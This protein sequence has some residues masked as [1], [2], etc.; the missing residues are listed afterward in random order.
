MKKIKLSEILKLANVKRAIALMMALT[1]LTLAGCKGN[2]ASSS[3]GGSSSEPSKVE[4]TD[5]SDASSEETVDSSADSTTTPSITTPSVTTPVESEDTNA[6]TS[7]YYIDPLKGDISVDPSITTEAPRKDAEELVPTVDPSNLC[8]KYEGYAQKE[9]DA[10]LDEILNTKNTLEY[11]KPKKGAK[12]YYVSPGGNNANDGLSHENAIQTID[13]VY[14]L[15]LLPGDFVLFERNS[16]YRMTEAFELREGVTYGSY[17]EG[18]KPMFYGSSR[19]YAKV[20]WKPSKKKNVWQTSYLDTYPCGMFFNEGE[21]FGYLKLTLRAVEKNTDFFYDE[22]NATFY[23]YCDR[24]N[25]SNVWDSIEISQDKSSFFLPS[26][27]DDVV[28]DNISMRYMGNGGVYSNYINNRWSVTNCEIGFCGGTNMG[29]VRGGNGIGSW[30]GGQYY[31]WDHNWVYQ[32]FDNGMSPQGNTGRGVF[33]DYH[34]ISYS[35]NL[36]EFNNADIELWESGKDGNECKHYNYW[37]NNNICRFTSLGWGTRADDGG[38]RG[39]DGVHY[40]H[41]MADQI[42]GTFQFNNNIID[43]PGR[44]L[45]KFDTGNKAVFD[46]FERKG[47]TYYIKQSMRT[48]TDL[49]YNF[50]W[51]DENTRV[52]GHSAVNEEQTVAAIKEMEP[53]VKAIYWY[54]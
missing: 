1:L 15:D 28:I 38:I 21:E 2:P 54:Q 35:N 6:S 23:V 46:A 18:R 5:S 3:E 17:G 30:C 48:I 42:T 34:D 16:V 47:N 9:R 52:G 31:N 40:G 32:T 14:G 7:S 25:P 51:K 11:Y 10:L 13:G 33:G 4:S 22:E 39:I 44:M 12:I 37:M 45:Y 50:V 8:Y 19:N 26:Y 29:A 27:V 41:M 49:S 36:S 43:C 53:D 20:N 24:G